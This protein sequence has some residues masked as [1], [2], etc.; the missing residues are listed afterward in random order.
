MKLGNL[1][2]SENSVYFVNKDGAKLN[3]ST[4]LGKIANRLY[5]YLLDFKLLLLNVVG[6]IPSHTFRNFCYRLSGMK[7]GKKAAIHM[8]ARFYDPRN[9]IIGSDSILGEGIVLDV[10]R[11]LM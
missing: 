2:L 1:V 11:F 6:A 5:S 10:V 7:L 9:I 8:G 4:A 3:S